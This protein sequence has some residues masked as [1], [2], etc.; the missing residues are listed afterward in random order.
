[1]SYILEGLKKL[2]QKRRQ[3]EGISGLPVFR[4]EKTS[5]PDRPVVWLYLLFIGLVLNAGVMVWWLGPWRSAD[6]TSRSH[7]ATA[8]P[9]TK[10]VKSSPVEN[11]TQSIPIPREGPQPSKVIEPPSQT[12]VV[13]KSKEILLPASKKPPA[14]RIPSGNT[15]SKPEPPS[16]ALT[17]VIPEGP[18]VRL[19][20]LPAEIKKNLPSIKLSVHYYN[21]D[22]QARFA[23]I[24]DRTLHEGETLGEGLRVVEI[25][26]EGTV[27]NFR[28]HRFLITINDNF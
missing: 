11:K 7:P 23:I 4:E 27:L 13:E 8:A 6:Y 5:R 9:A 21:M 15:P 3:E 12:P 28:G 16:P 14:P 22:K 26:P 18:I 24:N 10:V 1:M 2:E 20:D 19:N 17:K 25:N